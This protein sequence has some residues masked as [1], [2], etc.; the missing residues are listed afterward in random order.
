MDTVRQFTPLTMGWC[1]DCHRKT[2]VKMEGNPY[3][4]KLHEELKKTYGK[5]PITVSMMG[6]IECGKCHY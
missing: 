2:E 3:Y 4:N 6:G 5:K 1:I